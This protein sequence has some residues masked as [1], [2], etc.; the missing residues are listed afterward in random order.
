MIP[1]R[2]WALRVIVFGIIIVVPYCTIVVVGVV[3]VGVEFG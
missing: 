3:V 2:V 1:L